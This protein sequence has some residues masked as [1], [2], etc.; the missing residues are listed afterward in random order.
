MQGVAKNIL[1]GVLKFAYVLGDIFTLAI[2]LKI[3]D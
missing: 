1:F 3:S 2:I